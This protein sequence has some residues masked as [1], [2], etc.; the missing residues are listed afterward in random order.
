MLK[1][2]ITTVFRIFFRNKVYSYINIIGLSIAMACVIFILMWIR[3]ELSYDTFHINKDRLYLI[4]IKEANNPGG[5]GNDNAPYALAPILAYEC[6]EIENYTRL[7]K[8]DV[9]GSNSVKTQRYDGDQVMFYEDNVCLV[10][11]GFFSMF[12]FPFVHGNPHNALPNQNSIVINDK[13]AEKYFGDENPIGKTLNYNNQLN[14]VVSGVIHVPPNSHLQYDF[15]GRMF[16]DMRTNWNWRDPSYILIKKGA[17]A[18]ELQKKIADALD[19]HSSYKSL[20]VDILPMGKVHL[21][22]GQKIYIYIFAV[23]AALILLIACINYMNLS[24]SIMLSRTKEVGMRKVIGANRW[25]LIKQFLFESITMSF[26]AVII[27]GFLVWSLLP[28]FN[29]FFQKQVILFSS[30]SLFLFSLFSAMAFLVGIISGIYPALV[31]SSSKAISTLKVMLFFKSDR[32]PFRITSV[33]G[34]FAISIILIACT[35]VIY[36]QMQ[37]I[38]NRALGMDTD[39]IIKVPINNTLQQNFSTYKSALLRNPNILHVTAGQADPYNEGAKTQNISWDGKNPNITASFHYSITEFDFI[40]TFNM[41]LKK[42]RSFSQQFTTDRTQYIINEKAA[43]YM[44]MENPVGENLK[45]FNRDGKII[46]VIQDYHHQS[47]REEILPTVILI[48]QDFYSFLKY[49]YIKIKSDNIPS[50]LQYIQE[51]TKLSAPDFPFEYSFLDSEID[52]LYNNEQRLGRI[53]SYFSL[54]AILIALLGLFGLATFTV[55]HRI[56]EIGVRKILGS[57]VTSIVALIV[58]GYTKWILFANL[59]AWPIAYFVI[60]KWLQNF[61]YRIDL[62]IWPFLLAGSVAFLIAL[63]TISWQAIRAATANPVKALRYE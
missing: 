28:Y 49:I 21:Y 56:K 35:S 44:G 59:I 32:S 34:Q 17:S 8:F 10:D 41:K 40:E 42:G 5:H 36:K 51:T 60:N 6:P 3:D 43:A 26:V 23:I 38:K 20:I 12:S 29:N 52:N 62:T 4:N 25:H 48:N 24:T 47:L 31:L 58:K 50:S 53:F 19:R 2:Y 9:Y 11:T 46:G 27:A 22:F 63:L 1:N 16:N 7:F 61:A 37:F 55:Q 14:F 30:N 57:S 18:A 39:Y 54:L 45:L 15:I 33:V 13:I